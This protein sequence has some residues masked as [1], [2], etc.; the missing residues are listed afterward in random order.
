MT[1]KEVV[2]KPELGMSVFHEDILN[3]SEPMLVVGIRETTVELK[4]RYSDRMTLHHPKWYP[5]EG[6][7][8]LRKVCE[9]HENGKSCPLHNLH[10][11]YPNCEPYI[12]N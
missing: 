11:S 12:T 7:F 2:I 9:Y 10:C 5:I 6:L 8:R 1:K 4:G 3:G